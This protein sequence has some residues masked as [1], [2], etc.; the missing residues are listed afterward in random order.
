MKN[1]PAHTHV[2]KLQEPF[3]AARTST[4]VQS[5]RS[6]VVDSCISDSATVYF[7][8]WGEEAGGGASEHYSRDKEGDQ[9]RETSVRQERETSLRCEGADDTA[10]RQH[11]TS[12]WTASVSQARALLKARNA[13]AECKELGA[14]LKSPGAAAHLAFRSPAHGCGCMFPFRHSLD[15]FLHIYTCNIVCYVHEYFV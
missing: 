6:D 15:S 7:A 9:E 14:R 13:L 10:G 8:G 2:A 12:Q 4:A 11:A 1:K 5:T 3:S